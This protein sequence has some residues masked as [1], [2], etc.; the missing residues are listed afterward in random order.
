[1]PFDVC[2]SV[3]QLCPSLCD[4]MDCS[5]P[6]FPVFHHLLEFAQTHVHWVGYASQLSHPLSPPFPPD[7]SLFQNQGLFP[8]SWLFP[9]DGQSIGA[10]ASPLP[11]NIQCWFPLVLNGLISLLPKGLSGVFPAPQ[12]ESTN[13]L[14]L[15]LLY[16]PTREAI[17]DY[18]KN[19]SFNYMDLCRQDDVSAF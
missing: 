16:G 7:F 1:M 12:I 8:M 17:N 14:V 9:S 19:H 5:L 2:C 13:S 10:P 6:D 4:R 11:M 3:T 18:W 15:S